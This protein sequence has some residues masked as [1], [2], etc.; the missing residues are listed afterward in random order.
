[1]ASYLGG[2]DAFDCSIGD[3][4]ERYAGQNEQDCEQFVKATN[5]S[6]A[7]AGEGV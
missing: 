7:E 3:F 4:S 1:M 2:D 6:R 5:S